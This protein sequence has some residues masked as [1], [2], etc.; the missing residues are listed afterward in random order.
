MR[1][2][3]IFLILVL[4]I[5]SCATKKERAVKHVH[6]ALRLDPQVLTE[7]NTPIRLDTT[8]I[9]KDTIITP[10]KKIY[11]GVNKDSLR[12]AMEAELGVKTMLVENGKLKLELQQTKEGWFEFL[13]TVKPDTVPIIDTVYLEI[14]TE[15]PVK[16][17][18]TT[19]TKKGYFY[20]SGLI[21]NF[22]GGLLLL[23]L[24]WRLFKK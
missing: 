14:V 17:L 8:I 1:K 19:I 24:L 2:L 23:I 21:A 6:K 5:S 3:L 4:L 12:K 7:F 9:R 18:V 13:A 11:L 16:G 22:V 15:V 10:E 20:Y